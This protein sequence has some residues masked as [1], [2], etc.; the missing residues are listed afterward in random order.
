M[1]RGRFLALSAA[2]LGATVAGMP[3]LAGSVR[4]QEEAAGATREFSHRGVSVRLETAGGRPSI[5][6]DGQTFGVVD[7]NGAY[8]AAGFM[9]SPQPSL[10]RFAQR[11][12]ENRDRIAVEGGASRWT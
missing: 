11:V 4:A 1:S 7:T 6:I 10:E 5:V 3:L 8:R 9:Y 12:V 2:G